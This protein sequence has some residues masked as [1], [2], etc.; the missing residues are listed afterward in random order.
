M[1]VT[2]Q[3]IENVLIIQVTGRIDHITANV[4]EQELLPHL[5]DCTGEEKKAVL[6]LSRVTYMSSA[7]LRVLLLAAKQCRKQQGE[8]VVAALQPFLQEVFRISRFH[9]VFTIFDTVKAALDAISPAAAA[10][11]DGS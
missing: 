11:Y 8:L 6:D 10:V 3:T 4:F 1:G 2:T 9:V 5:K 7:G